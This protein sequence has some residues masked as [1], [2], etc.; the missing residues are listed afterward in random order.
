MIELF[1][2]NNINFL[3]FLENNFPAEH[4]EK[5]VQAQNQISEKVQISKI[6]DLFPLNCHLL[7][8]LLCLN[9]TIN[10]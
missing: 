7:N 1:F 6:V 3:K 8:Q 4:E 2:G 5:H 10:Q 9:V